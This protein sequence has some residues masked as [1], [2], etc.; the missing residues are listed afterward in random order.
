MGDLQLLRLVCQR[1]VGKQRA[2]LF[3]GR[4][5]VEEGRCV[6]LD[7]GPDQLA[8]GDNPGHVGRLECNDLLP[9]FN[10]GV[11]DAHFVHQ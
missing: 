2:R 5:V 3:Q 7:A 11:V 4:Q 8:D 1:A 6:L 10:G 9:P